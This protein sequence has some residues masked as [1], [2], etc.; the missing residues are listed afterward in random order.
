[1]ADRSDTFRM[2][3]ISLFALIGGVVTF[4]VIGAYIDLLWVALGAGIGGA[5]GYGVR[6][7]GRR[8]RSFA[9]AID[10]S[11]SATKTELLE[12]AR[13]LDVPGRST[14]DKDELVQA[15]AEKRED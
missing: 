7:Y 9:A 12:E 1:M 4:V 2:N 15:I 13:R 11:E 10:L 14:M 8:A 5:I 3:P 6:Q